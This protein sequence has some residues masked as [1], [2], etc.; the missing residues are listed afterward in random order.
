MPDIMLSGPDGQFSAY[1][2][3]PEPA[4]G[5][6]IVVIQEI[7][8]VNA[9]MRAHCDA[10][11]QDGYFALCPD[12]FWRQE[13]GVQITDQTEAE[14]QKAFALF[15]GFDVDLGVADLKL[16]LAHLRGVD[17]CT[18]KV[19]S[20][21]F[22]L[23][24]LLAYLMA[25]RTDADCNVAY[26]GVGIQDRLAEAA[27][28]RTPTLLHIAEEDEFVPRDAQQ[29][30]IAHFADNPLVTTQ[31]YPGVGH[32][33]ARTAGVHFDAAA[34]ELAAQRTRDHFAAHLR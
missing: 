9:D 27:Q 31:L 13:P 15:N 28:I 32:A 1:L 29:A 2:A 21:G 12:L 34:T 19:G 3:A 8:G 14:W 6:G 20:I 18:A 4:A 30:V 22:C 25:T 33:F 16:A 23:G 26:Y 11:A 7:F 24:G 10:L 5:P 17:G